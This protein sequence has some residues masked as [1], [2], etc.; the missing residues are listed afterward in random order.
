VCRLDQQTVDAL[1]REHVVLSVAS[2]SGPDTNVLTYMH[3]NGLT[4]PTLV[5]SDGSLAR[6]YGVRAFPTFF[7]INS[8]GEIRSTEVGYTTRWGLLAR[9]FLAR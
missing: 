8:S 9:L 2:E 6:R 3:Q 4:F 7:V 1:S 5:D